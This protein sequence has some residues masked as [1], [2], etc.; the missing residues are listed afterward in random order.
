MF[1]RLVLAWMLCLGLIAQDSVVVFLRHAEKSSKRTNAELS[2]RGKQRAQCLVEELSRFQP[3]ALFASDL[4]RTQQTLEPLS[5]RLKLP[6]ETYERGKE[7]A[8]GQ[9]L[10]VRFPGQTVVVC[11]HSDTL[12]DLVKA[13]GDSTP[14]PEVSGFDRFWVLR[15]AEP[16]GRVTLQEHR[17]RPLPGEV[18]AILPAVSQ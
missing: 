13:L 9:S 7:H 10:L 1:Y 18:R 4:R 11:G 16:G 14:F 5:K 3:V 8:L 2:S 12:M 17:Q 6:L 15:I